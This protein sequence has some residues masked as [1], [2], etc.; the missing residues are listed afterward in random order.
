MVAYRCDRCKEY[1]IPYEGL[2]IWGTTGD[3]VDAMAFSKRLNSHLTGGIEFS[4]RKRYDL[5]PN[6]ME[7]IIIFMKND[8][9][10]E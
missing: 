4:D 6:C 1:Y 9:Q 10:K 3:M 8:V 7:K 5:C 2:N